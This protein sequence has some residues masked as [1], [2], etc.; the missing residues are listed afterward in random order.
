MEE[1]EEDKKNANKNHAA[2]AA[3]TAESSQLSSDEPVAMKPTCPA[4]Q[5]QSV[6][7]DGAKEPKRENQTIDELDATGSSDTSN[8]S[9]GG[10]GEGA[11]RFKKLKLSH[12]QYRDRSQEDESFLVNTQTTS[13]ND[14]AT[15]SGGGEQPGPEAA[16][17]QLATSSSSS[18]SSSDDFGATFAATFSE[19]Q[20]A[21][22]MEEPGGGL[23]G[24]LSTPGPSDDDE[25]VEEGAD[26]DT[27]KQFNEMQLKAE[28]LLK[29]SLPRQDFNLCNALL[30]SRVT[31]HCAW[32]VCQERLRG[33]P[34]LV[35][36][37]KLHCKL[38]GHDGC[39]NA[40][41]FNRT[42][43]KIASGS[44]DLQ[45]IIW[46]WQRQKPLLN[47]DSGHTENVFQSKF[48]GSDDLAVA[49]CSRD[50]Q[51][52]LARLAPD[53]SLGGTSKLVEH[54][55]AAHKLDLL[56]LGGSQG[57]ILSAG[58]D[59]RVFCCDTR[60]EEGE[61]LMLLKNERGATVPIYS[62]HNNPSQSQQFCTAGR[63]QYIRVFDR[64]F[65]NNGASV[66][67]YCPKHLKTENNT[68]AYITSAV[69]NFDGSEVIGSYSDDDIFM[70][71]TT[72]ALDDADFCRRYTGHKNSATVKGVNYYGPKSEFVISGSDCGNIFFWSKDT[73]GIV[74]MTKG[75][76]QGVVNV[77]EGHPSLPVLA[78]SGLDDQVKIW[79]P[80]AQQPDDS[81]IDRDKRYK[82]MHKTVSRHLFER[83]QSTRG[84]YGG[85]RMWRSIWASRFK[86]RRRRRREAAAAAGQPLSSDSEEEDDDSDSDIEDG[87]HTCY[88]S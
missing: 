62:I 9:S 5:A 7:N 85:L 12:R 13:E 18:S 30:A 71:E 53:G 26:E 37:L 54:G 3:L 72:N 42:G 20:A 80:N 46:D 11:I 6:S 63:D 50:G 77:L 60:L 33:S 44:D 84:L 28:Q 52:R 25:E 34:G 51:V 78:T 27:K 14:A 59:G 48:L 41:N 70:F 57:L 31:P 16:V 19:S 32:K 21:S 64:R 55:S 67:K 10:G 88:L 74:H 29:K 58:E 22:D 39:V 47:F 15:S 86:A 35:Q 79:L 36:R 40:L 66:A 81:E 76:D 83:E 68:M 2:A 1:G 8:L 45:I 49:S 38:E 24:L 4:D 43:D 82:T 87:R 56:N 75:D 65:I 73:E 23:E 17:P 69:F 61:K